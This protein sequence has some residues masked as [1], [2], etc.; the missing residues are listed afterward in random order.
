M[1]TLRPAALALMGVVLGLMVA[2]PAAAKPLAARAVHADGWAAGL[3]VAAQ[4]PADEVVLPSR[5]ANA[6]NRLTISLNAA[7]EAVDTGVSA[8]AAAAFKAIQSNVARTD[9]AARAQ[10]TAVPPPAE[11]A[12]IAQ[13]EGSTS[14]PDSV[15][16]V[17]TAQQSAITSLAGLFD[18]KGGATVDGAT[19][20]LF[21]TMNTRDKLLDAVIGLDPEGAGAAYADGMADTVAGYDDEVANI[22]EAIAGDKLSTGGGKVLRAALAKSQATQAKM[23]TAFGGGE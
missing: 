10:M 14:G 5:V 12:R 16:A 13:E 8:K 7:Q 15:V 19:H 2:S 17:L 21:A 4:E 9:R 11:E 20:A 23:T 6:I 18:N 3:R 22:S 1:R